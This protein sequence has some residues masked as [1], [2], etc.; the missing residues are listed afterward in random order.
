MQKSYNESLA[1]Y[2]GPE[3]CG[4]S[5]NTDAE[6]LTGVR[7]GW[8]DDRLTVRSGDSGKK[9]ATVNPSWIS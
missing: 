8:R 2:I 6:A 5:S 1:S 7:A 3:S 4:N 9:I